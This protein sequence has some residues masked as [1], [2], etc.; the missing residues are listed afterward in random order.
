MKPKTVIVL[1]VLLI[2]CVLFV[3]LRHA[4]LFGGDNKGVLVFGRTLKQL[5]TLRITDDRGRSMAFVRDGNL[6][7]MTEPVEATAD[8]FAIADLVTT[9]QELT[10]T[11]RLPGEK[12]ASDLT[13]LAEPTWT[14]ELTADGKSFRLKVGRQ[15]PVMGDRGR[16]TYVQRADEGDKAD[17]HSVAVNF[18][19]LLRRPTSAFRDRTVFGASVDR[20][21]GLAVEGK[22]SYRLTRDGGDWTLQTAQFTAPADPATVRRALMGLALISA[23]DF[24]DDAAADLGVYGLAP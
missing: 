6:W 7:R 17:V 24:I 15:A 9:L 14:I 8:M 1:A 13:G 21:A 23:E 11:K 4:D 10:S 16:L 3:V 2:A 5:D 12:A 19:D 20:I 22:H 18:E